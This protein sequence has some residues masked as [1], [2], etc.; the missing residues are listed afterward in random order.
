MS[1]TTLKCD[2]CGKKTRRSEG[3]ADAMRNIFCTKECYYQS[4]GE[5]K[6]CIMR[7]NLFKEFAKRKLHDVFYSCDKLQL[8]AEYLPIG[9]KM[10]DPRDSSKTTINDTRTKVILLMFGKVRVTILR[11]DEPFNMDLVAT[12]DE[13]TDK[14]VMVIPAG[15]SHTIENTGLTSANLFTVYHS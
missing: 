15:T 7:F 12:G 10:K 14:N 5:T 6:A 8:H 13:E 4:D 3:Y 1:E 11:D 9:E 2:A